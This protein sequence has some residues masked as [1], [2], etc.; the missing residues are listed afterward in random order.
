VGT[1]KIQIVGWSSGSTSRLRSQ[2]DL[3]ILLT[4][5]DGKVINTRDLFFDANV[6]AGNVV[7]NKENN[8]EFEISFTLPSTNGGKLIKTMKFR[9]GNM[10]W[11]WTFSLLILRRLWQIMNTS[12]PGKAA[13][14]TLNATA[15]TKQISE[16]LMLMPET[17]WRMSMQN[18]SIKRNKKIFRGYRLDCGQE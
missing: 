2:G 11:I 15:S 5:S 18:R 16:R 10:V 13:F 1:E 8:Y 7:L 14:D 6:P 4:T 17:N 3:T 12:L 9:N